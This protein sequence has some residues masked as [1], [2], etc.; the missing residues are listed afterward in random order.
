MCGKNFL[1]VEFHR[2]DTAWNTQESGCT[3]ALC[4]SA[5]FVEHSFR[6]DPRNSS[7]QTQ[8]QLTISMYLNSA[9]GK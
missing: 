8:L 5:I 7:V 6:E 2:N 1:W 9:I 4:V 3:Q